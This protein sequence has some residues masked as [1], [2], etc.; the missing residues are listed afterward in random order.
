MNG[1][2][3]SHKF[4][5][6]DG[7]TALP[8]RAANMAVDK[9]IL[10]VCCAGNEG[11][12]VGSPA[13]SPNVLSVGAIDKTGNIG[14]FTV[15]GITVDGRM[16]PDVVSLGQGAYTIGTD[17]KIDS[18]SGTSYAS[19]IMCGLAACLWQVYP[20]LTNQELLNL[21]KKS[22]DKY[23][24]PKLPFGYGIVDI[25]KAIDLADKLTKKQLEFLILLG[26]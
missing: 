9:G 12:W 22:A 18:R 11:A 3:L 13:D 14:F 24:V 1:L 6:M 5:E 21:L 26:F 8:T 19:P 10:I 17:G 16:K 25:R 23:D 20:E 15:Y 4:E 2:F 7:K